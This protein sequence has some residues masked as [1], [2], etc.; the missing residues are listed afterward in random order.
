VYENRVLRRVFGPKRDEMT[1]GVEKKL[2]NEE[3]N[4]LYGSPNIIRVIKLRRMR[5]VGSVASLGKGEEHTGFWWRNLK[6]SEHLEDPGVDRRI[7]LRW[8]FRKW[9][10]NMN[11]IG[12][13][14]DR[15]RCRVLLN[16]VL[17]LRF[18]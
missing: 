16:A 11:W 10:R 9:D 2:Q 17:S 4:V 18:Q 8:I 14:Q 1:R 6:K 7:I 15:D 13:A 12:L 3:L 5:W